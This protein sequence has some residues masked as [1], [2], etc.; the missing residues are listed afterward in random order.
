[1]KPKLTRENF[2]GPWAGIPV[3]WDSNFQ[4]NEKN[5]YNDVERCCKAGFPGVYTGGTTGEF[6]AM[7]FEEFK[8]VSSI[9]VE[10][11]HKYNV[12]VMIGC[13]STYTIGAIE[14]AK[15]AEQIGADAIQLTLPFWMEVDDHCVVDFFK[16]V[17]AEVHGLVLSIYE[18]TRSK[19][20]LTLEQHQQIKKAI[21][22]YLMVKANSDTIGD[23]ITGCREL[24]KFVNVFV[25]EDRWAELGPVGAQGACASLIYWF[26]DFTSRLWKSVESKDWVAVNEGCAAISYLFDFLG[27]QFKGRGF[28]DSA[29]DKI[30]GAV[31]NFLSGG[32]ICRRP[33]PHGNSDDIQALMGWCEKNYPEML[34]YSPKSN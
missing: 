13:S 7:D 10:V 23:T 6:Y 15:F 28:T 29:M 26:P 12:P 8:R 11:C 16:D 27:K 4:L 1:M 14:H 20:V 33:Y 9:T 5:Y 19:K 2:K 25:G 17:M 22:N 24:S 3:A 21:P 31:C 34:Q 18:T 30:G 32:L